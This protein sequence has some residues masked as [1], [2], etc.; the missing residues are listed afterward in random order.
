MT[1][2]SQPT[3]LTP[4]PASEP[5]APAL[6]F[7]DVAVSFKG[8]V[9]VRGVTLEVPARQV[10]TLVGP[11]GLRQD[12]VAESGQPHARPPRRPRRRSYPAG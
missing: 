5:V 9:A 2:A 4:E 7:E 8:H 3:V 10:T 1:V 12:H 11:L 6:R